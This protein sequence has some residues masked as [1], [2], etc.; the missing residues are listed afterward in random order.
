MRRSSPN[1][2]WRR[3]TDREPRMAEEQEEQNPADTM[4]RRPSVVF[5]WRNLLER[6]GERL[7]LQA[8]EPRVRS[9]EGRD[10]VQ[11]VEQNIERKVARNA[12][13]CIDEEQEAEC[14][15]AVAG[16]RSK[17]T[18]L[19]AAPAPASASIRTHCAV[20]P[21][22]RT[23]TPRARLAMVSA[24]SSTPKTSSRCPSADDVVRISGLAQRDADQRDLPAERI[25]SQRRVH[26]SNTSA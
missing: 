14:E 17:S 25:R 24:C 2:G 4:N 19:D 6:L 7:P 10:V 22:G 12:R 5:S 8:E 3:L 16:R 21:R 26:R 11:R 1:W 15:P 18:K 20:G 9:R 23:A 13:G